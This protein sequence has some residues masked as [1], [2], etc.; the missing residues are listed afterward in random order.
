MSLTH[1]DHR[2]IPPNEHRGNP[3][4]R[5]LTVQYGFLDHQSST[6]AANECSIMPENQSD[7]RIGDEQESRGKRPSRKISRLTSQQA[8]RKRDLDRS[9]QQ[10]YRQRV[11]SRIENLEEE[12]DRMK[13]DSGSS[14]ETLLRK[15]QTLH[16]ENHD[17]KTRLAS[18]Y[19]LAN[20]ANPIATPNRQRPISRSSAPVA[21]ASIQPEIHNDHP[22]GNQVPSEGLIAERDG[23]ASPEHYVQSPHS[24]PSVAA[25]NVIGST[26]DTT[27][28][29]NDDAIIPSPRSDALSTS[30]RQRVPQ[31]CLSHSEN[32]PGDGKFNL[33]SNFC[34]K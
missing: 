7:S 22:A 27:Y 14:Q 34:P 16:D 29:Q 2:I 31:P 12:L 18:I 20:I 19:Q 8:Q 23:P 28:S 33:L 32:T 24:I 17:L 26:I 6:E 30:L 1:D 13:A 21:T 5:T 9:S 10:A 25:Q 15:I 4:L 11:K 3:I